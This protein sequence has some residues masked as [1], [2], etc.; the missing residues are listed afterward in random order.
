MIIGFWDNNCISANLQKA[1]VTGEIK[2]ETDTDIAP[3]QPEIQKNATLKT[4]KRS[5]ILKK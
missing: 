1:I 4:M 3:N 5:E 2:S